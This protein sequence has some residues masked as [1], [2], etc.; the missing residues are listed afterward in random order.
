MGRHKFGSARTDHRHTPSE[1][2]NIW[3]ESEDDIPDPKEPLPGGLQYREPEPVS[4]ETLDVGPARP[5]YE[6]MMAHGV[7]PDVHYGG[8]PAP[9]PDAREGERAEKTAHELEYGPDHAMPVYVV[10]HE[11]PTH[12]I[13][14]VAGKVATVPQTSI[15]AVQLCDDDPSRTRVL[16]LN[17]TS[18]AVRV[19]FERTND[20]GPLLP[21][22]MTNYLPLKTSKAIYAVPV[23]GASGPTT[24]SLIFE[25]AKEG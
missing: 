25:Y 18:Q 16:L 3:T 21:G 9:K 10:E 23:A 7:K 17:E 19:L 1:E 8:R 24:I 15:E 4:H 5:Y 11:A 20:T 12:P 2:G 6:G 22:S 14:G 13:R